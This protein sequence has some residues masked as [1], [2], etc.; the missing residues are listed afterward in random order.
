[1]EKP[2]NATVTVAPLSLP[3]SNGTLAG[4]GETLNGMGPDGILSLSLPLPLT[5]G[6]GEAP[7]LAL[8][9]QSANGNGSF[10]LGWSC[11]SL[12]IARETRHGVPLWQDSDPFV[13]PDGELLLPLLNSAGQVDTQMRTSIRGVTTAASTVT[14]YRSRTETSFSR[15]E[16]WVPQADKTNAFWLIYTADGGVHCLGKTPAC[17]I[18][19]PQQPTQ[20]AVW[21]LEESVSALGEHHYYQYLAEDEVGCSA[22]EINA[23]TGTVAQRY[24]SQIYYGNTTASTAPF[25]LNTPFN[26]ANW[27]FCLVFDYGQYGS[28]QYPDFTPTATWGVRSDCFS[29]YQYGFD[30][31]TRRLCRQILMF[32]RVQALEGQT[33]STNNLQLCRRLA[34]QYDHNAV[35]TSLIAA[36]QYGIDATE[37]TALPPLEFAWQAPASTAGL[38]WQKLSDR[39][40]FNFQQG[41]QLVDLYGEGLVGILY[42]HENAWWYRAPIRQADPLNPDS[43]TNTISWSVPAPLPLA[44]TSASNAL[45]MDITQDGRP[46]WLITQ[47][48][49]QGYFT[50]DND[51]HWST[52]IPL[53]AFPSEFF[54]PS[55]QI[56]DLTGKDQPDL[57]LIGPKS[58]RLW[59]SNEKRWDSMKEVPYDK[60][61]ALPIAGYDQR[62]LVAFSDLLGSGQQHLTEIRADGVTVWPN[63][64]RGRFGQALLLGG[65]SIP[66]DQFN[67]SRVYLADIDGSGTSD[68]IY[69]Q[70]DRIQV[71]INQSGNGFVETDSIA[72]PAGVRFDDSCQ[73]N[74]GDLQGLG[75]ASLLLTRPYPS[76]QHWRCDL[77]SAKPW[78]LSAMNNNMGT[79][80]SFTYRSSAQFWLDQ[81]QRVAPNEP[82]ACRLPFPIQVLWQHQLLDEITGNKLISENRFYQGVWE[83]KEREFRGFA[84]VEQRDTSVPAKQRTDT[85][86]MLIRS[87]YATGVPEVD[88]QLPA[89]YWQG[90]P[91]AYRGY[92]HYLTQWLGGKDQPLGTNEDTW[93]LYRAL[94]GCLLRSE[95]YGQ[96]ASTQ[97]S[98]PYSVTESRWQARRLLQLTTPVVMAMQL[99][100]RTYHYER[101]SR[102]PQISQSVNL[103]FDATGIALDSLNIAYPRRTGINTAD[104]PSDLLP[105]SIVPNSMD[106]QQQLAYLTRVRQRTITLDNPNA[107][108][109]RLGLA[110]QQ[111]TDACALAVSRVPSQGFNLEN[112]I[113]TNGVMASPEALS[114]INAW[115]YNGEWTFASKTQTYY[116]AN[117]SDTPVAQPSLQALVA[118]TETS[119]FDQTINTL[120]T[121]VNDSKLLAWGYRKMV[122]TKAVN[123]ASQPIIIW[124]ARQGYTDYGGATQFWQPLA[125]R[126]SALT[127]KTTL[128]WDKYFC[129]PIS[130]TDAAGLITRLTYDYRYM[131]PILL[132]DANN[133]QHQSILDGMGRAI[134][135]RFEGTENGQASGY[136]PWNKQKFLLSQ[137]IDSAISVQTAIPLAGFSLLAADSW[138]VNTLTASTSQL[139]TGLR[140]ILQ[141]AGIINPSGRLLSLAWQRYRQRNSTNVDV[142]A[143]NNWL[144]QQGNSTRLPPHQLDVTTDRYDTDTAQQKRQVVRFSDGM[145]R[146]LQSAE[147][148]EK[149]MA[150][151]RTA[152]GGL[153]VDSQ[154][155]LV[156]AM[157]NSR[158]AVSGKTE[159]NNKGL[160]IRSYQ[161]YYLNDWR[162]VS[163]DSSRM[164]NGLYS[165]IR[166]YEATGREIS[167]ETAKGYVR[168]V[169]Y[170]PWFKV[171]E[172][173]ND[174]A[175]T[176]Q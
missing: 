149:G 162:Y 61:P 123:N 99:E 73:I 42:Q 172:D 20:V 151:Q 89:Q 39:E 133:N 93:W 105:D 49:W 143:L 166:F 97:A 174:T 68:I 72:L 98:I 103:Q 54:H 47:P 90:D 1:M 141:T 60:S 80:H 121:E 102:D 46:D 52:F 35:A 142:V 155:V 129:L 160:A 165:D 167:V 169:R 29:R 84:Y 74:I 4:M 43:L 139:S 41:Y 76:V 21:L 79:H 158:W 104:Y 115:Y 50:L 51:R 113:Q 66:L 173:E 122:D 147:R 152:A 144:Q 33:G 108:L 56:Q 24:L 161:P 146:L 67:P 7:N 14:R 95:T 88:Q 62:R 134:A 6:R 101:I 120:T 13:G 106:A 3:K 119:V 125:Q 163:D 44:P 175:H 26:A 176:L 81:K 128:S 157:A 109:W 159:Y 87:W 9:Y 28:S 96:D 110:D 164:Q 5:A 145:G 118:F 48:G 12:T 27:L 63:L 65:F 23:H 75:V 10:G 57:V 153:V 22:A 117:T 53:D 132:I 11:E 8:S 31:R 82:V 112:L 116:T 16:L 59:V 15:F 171:D 138:M 69:L 131:Q 111:R 70:Y 137:S 58:V 71:F 127:G 140:N 40:N 34:L 32:H 136:S 38:V 78:L 17:R 37:P 168:R 148:H 107:D 156:E 55:A 18:S 25:L 2:N 114:D 86:P 154:G 77:N 19:N 100:S 130:S 45:L 85:P 124:G 170:F 92:S 135:S 64:G 94:S 36:C 30:I 83:P 150:W 126:A 91:L